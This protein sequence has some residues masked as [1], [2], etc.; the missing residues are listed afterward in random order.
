MVP[1]STFFSRE[2]ISF[3]LWVR[4]LNVPDKFTFRERTCYGDPNNRPLEKWFF[5]PRSLWTRLRHVC[6]FA[7][8][9]PYSLIAFWETLAETNHFC[10]CHF[11]PL[12]IAVTCSKLLPLKSPP[13]GSPCCQ[14]FSHTGLPKSSQYWIPSCPKQKLQKLL[15]IHR[16]KHR[17]Q[18]TL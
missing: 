2:H 17:P 1:P 13:Q 10:I 18:S 16:M 3:S 7:T 9:W 12:A 11:L 5:S 8:H 6:L 14:P 4:E 15:N